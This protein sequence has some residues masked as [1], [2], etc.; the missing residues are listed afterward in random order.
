[1]SKMEGDSGQPRRVSSL[2]PQVVI[3]VHGK[4]TPP[5][6]SLQTQGNEDANSPIREH[7][8]LINNGFLNR[9]WQ[10][11]AEMEYQQ[12]LK[13]IFRLVLVA[14]P[15]RIPSSSSSR[16]AWVKPFREFIALGGYNAAP[17]Q[18]ALQR[19]QQAGEMKIAE[20]LNLLVQ[21]QHDD[22]AKQAMHLFPTLHQQ[23]R[24]E[25]A[26]SLLLL[27]L[28]LH[29]RATSEIVHQ[30]P[31]ELEA[32]VLLEKLEAC[33][34]ARRLS[35]AL[36]DEPCIAWMLMEM[37]RIFSDLL[38]AELSTNQLPISEDYKVLISVY[39]EALMIYRRLAQQKPDVYESEL[40]SVLRDL[41][42][43]YSALQVF[44]EAVNNLQEA[45]EIYRRLAASQ[46]NVYDIDLAITLDSLGNAL[47]G[48]NLY[49]ESI[50]V[51]K[52][53]L[54]TYR[55]YADAQPEEHG[56][57]LVVL[58]I[59]LGNSLHFL[60]RLDEAAEVLEDALATSELL[61]Q[62]LPDFEPLVDIARDNLES[63]LSELPHRPS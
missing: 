54:P 36:N 63:V 21:G 33:E 43:T 39:Q 9:V 26:Y 62:R 45:S 50:E 32:E 49:E 16:A 18:D 41:G 19:A 7:P 38:H 27:P 13:T 11:I 10:T 55:K 4:D 8:I 30:Y 58:L 56:T 44:G 22:A 52:E 37:A 29:I 48:L 51:C 35:Y 28:D 20:L 31:S 12:A 46:S 14:P 61:A 42:L 40:A 25:E 57:A 17:L 3:V 1:M 24:L 47:Q 53:A 59:T 6:S 15:N 2:L 23:G 5:N 34:V 60:G